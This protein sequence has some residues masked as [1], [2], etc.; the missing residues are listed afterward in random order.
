MCFDEKDWAI[1]TVT[2]PDG[3]K[4]FKMQ[5]LKATMAEEPADFN[6]ALDPEISG[7]RQELMLWRL[8]LQQTAREK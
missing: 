3:K 1:F 5:I 6:R 4:I 8:M 2:A 7:L